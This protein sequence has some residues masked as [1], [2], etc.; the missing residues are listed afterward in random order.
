MSGVYYS[1]K[2][3]TWKNRFCTNLVPLLTA[4]KEKVSDSC[5]ISPRKRAPIFHPVL[6]LMIKPQIVQGSVIMAGAPYRCVWT[7]DLLSSWLLCV[8]TS[9]CPSPFRPVPCLPLS[10]LSPFQSL[11]P[12]LPHRTRPV[13]GLLKC[14]FFLAVLSQAV[15]VEIVLSWLIKYIPSQPPFLDAILAH[16]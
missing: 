15:A 9:L 3:N 8:E 6:S 4:D 11:S 12:A 2:F 14:C 10:R 16:L 5:P 13:P 1:L 7:A